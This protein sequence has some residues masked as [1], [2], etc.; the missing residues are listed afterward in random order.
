MDRRGTSDAQAD[1]QPAADERA[2]GPGVIHDLGNLI[3][4][5]ASAV[6]LVSRS[7]WAA[8]DP[9]LEPILARARAALDRA[10]VL[11]RQTLGRSREAALVVRGVQD[12]QDVAA[13]L[14]EIHALIQWACE[15]DIRLS[16]DTS[17]DLPAVRCNRIELQSAVLN[18]VINARDAMPEG[19]RLG[20]SVRAVQEGDL[21][22][23]V[24]IA[25]S[26]DGL[27]MSPE[28]LR[29]ATSPYFTTKPEGRG[30]GLGLAMVQRFAHDAGGRADIASAL[31][32]GTTVTLRLPAPATADVCP[33]APL[34]AWRRDGPGAPR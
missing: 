13:C 23:G 29:C 18:L 4:I 26:D 17:A 3:Q 2:G 6:S 27:G 34:S 9:S 1:V 15:P 16:V 5:A 30:T 14:A 21:A 33:C 10:G 22:P 31:G 20:L 25:V 24:A 8:C 7:P 32:A 12:L 19:G 11:V 28:T